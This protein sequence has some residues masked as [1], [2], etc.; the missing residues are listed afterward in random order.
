MDPFQPAFGDNSSPAP[1]ADPRLQPTPDYGTLGPGSDV[2][3]IGTGPQQPAAPQQAARVAATIAA[4]AGMFTALL[5]GFV[6][7]GNSPRSTFDKI[8]SQQEHKGSSHRISEQDGTGPQREAEGLLQRAVANDPEASQQISSQVDSWQGKL[9]WNSQMASLTT[10]ALNSNDM[11]VRESGVEVELAAYNLAKNSAS[12]EYVLRLSNSNNHAEKIWA[13]WA[14]GL[15]ANRG[16][17]ADR[18]LQVLISHLSDSDEDSRRW[19]V[20]SLSLTG[21]DR[22][23]DALLKAMHD[24]PSPKVRERA[25]CG[26]A[27]AGLFTPEQRMTAIPQLLSDSDDPSLDAR[28]HAWAFHALRDITHQQLPDDAAAWRSW[29]ESRNQSSQESG[30]GS[31]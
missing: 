14:L 15:M 30:I 6:A 28:T 24:D 22:S 11:R 20:E 12:L 13:L 23:I 27:Q 18:V 8:L 3:G 1:E 26:L 5:V 10:A 17:E 16:V 19:T 21:S 29:Y 25:A 4:L 2:S 7:R 9:H 31:Q